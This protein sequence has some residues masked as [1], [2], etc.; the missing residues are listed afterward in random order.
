[1]PG[2]KKEKGFQQKLLY[3]SFLTFIRSLEYPF[4]LFHILVIKNNNAKHC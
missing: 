1:M 4:E 3:A 2:K